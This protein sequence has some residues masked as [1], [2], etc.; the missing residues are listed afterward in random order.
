MIFIILFIILPLIAIGIAVFADKKLD[1][2]QIELK[3]NEI[4]HM[5]EIDVD[6]EDIL[7]K[8]AAK[9]VLYLTNKKLVLYRYKYEWLEFIPFIGNSIVALSMDTNPKFE[10]LLTDIKNYIFQNKIL[11][12]N[13][14]LMYKDCHVNLFTK[15]NIEYKLII[16]LKTVDDERAEIL[17]K[18][19]LLKLA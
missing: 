4:V 6:I 8:S 13:S 15:S 18:L 17:L 12:R 14:R 9:G 2:F 7:S 16:P 1:K 10:I 11:Y 5:K 19:D 3:A